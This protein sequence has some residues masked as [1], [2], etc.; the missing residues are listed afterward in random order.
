MTN[1][2]CRPRWFLY[3]MTFRWWLSDD[4]PISWKT[5]LSSIVIPLSLIY[6]QIE[7]SSRKVVKNPLWWR[8]QKNCWTFGRKPTYTY[9]TNSSHLCLIGEQAFCGCH[10][11]RQSAQL[12]VQIS[13]MM[14]ARSHVL[15]RSL[16]FTSAATTQ[17]QGVKNSLV[18]PQNKAISRSWQ[19]PRI[20]SECKTRRKTKKQKITWHAARFFA[21]GKAS[22]KFF[23][24]CKSFSE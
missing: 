8:L 17:L 23:E 5:C 20:W 19:D 24:F 3:M 11:W 10:A 7:R 18:S 12:S 9:H 1:V 13:V 16:R 6:C 15:L 22:V 2:E 14:R 4:L 21:G